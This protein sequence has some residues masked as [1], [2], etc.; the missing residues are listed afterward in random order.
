MVLKGLDVQEVSASD[1]QMIL[2]GL[3]K[4]GQGLL[5]SGDDLQRLAQV[6][7]ELPLDK[8]RPLQAAQLLEAKHDKAFIINYLIY[9]YICVLYL[10][11]IHSY[12]YIYELEES[13]NI[14]FFELA[15]T[16][17]VPH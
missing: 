1:L 16:S 7:L 10:H 13:R 3:A 15:G 17:A 9:I 4:A 8:R 6:A 5:W 2:H 11:I 14:Y 12:I